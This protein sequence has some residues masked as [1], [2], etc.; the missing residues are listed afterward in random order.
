MVRQR[1]SLVL[2]KPHQY[3]EGFSLIVVNGQVAFDGKAMTAAQP[4]KVLFGP[5]RQLQP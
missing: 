5:S 3:T 2:E 4:G 1:T